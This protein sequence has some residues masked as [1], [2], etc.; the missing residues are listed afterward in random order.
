MPRSRVAVNHL[1]EVHT[2][3]RRTVAR[4]REGACMLAV[5]DVVLMEGYEEMVV[6][7]D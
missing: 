1:A 4:R 6:V 5:G 2:M 3:M 7:G